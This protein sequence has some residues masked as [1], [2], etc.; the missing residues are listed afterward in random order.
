MFIDGVNTEV[1]EGFISQK[2][3]QIMTLEKFFSK[4][5]R[6]A[7][8]KCEKRFLYAAKVVL[9]IKELVKYSQYK[10]DATQLKNFLIL[11]FPPFSVTYMAKEKGGNFK[12]QKFL[13]WVASFL[14]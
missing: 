5:C 12:H 11:K 7:F 6:L 9:K 1:I 4:L 2:S 8:S 3:L 10:N 14:Y 13:N